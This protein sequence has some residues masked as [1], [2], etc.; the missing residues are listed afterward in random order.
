MKVKHQGAISENNPNLGIFKFQYRSADKKD[1]FS[2]MTDGAD[3]ADFKQ[4]G[5]EKVR[6]FLKNISSG[7]QSSLEF[8]DIPQNGSIKWTS[9]FTF[10]LNKIQSTVIPNESE[11]FLNIRWHRT[12]VLNL[13][14]HFNY[15]NLNFKIDSNIGNSTELKISLENIKNKMLMRFKGIKLDNTLKKEDV[16]EFVLEMDIEKWIDINTHIKAYEQTVHGLNSL[17][18]QLIPVENLLEELDEE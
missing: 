1:Q 6:S 17:L 7:K 15:H 18:S 5:V 9:P 12:N 10:K 4:T 3:L 8:N 11:D 16:F 13:D 2:F 14:I